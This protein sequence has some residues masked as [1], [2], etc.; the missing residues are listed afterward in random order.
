MFNL[1]QSI[2]EWRRRMITGGIKS[3]VPLEEL[4]NH[5]REHIQNQLCSGATTEQAF[6]TAAK[7][8]GDAHGLKREFEKVQEESPKRKRLRAASIVAG[9]AFAYGAVFT[10]WIL[11]RRS[12][13]I[14]ITATEFL[15]LLGSMAATIIF[16]FIGRR[17]AKLLPVVSNERLQAAAIVAVFFLGAGLLRFVWSCLML[18]SL[19][20]AQL[21]LLWTMSPILGF[22]HCL[23]AW[24]NQCSAARKQRNTVNV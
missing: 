5:L 14:E 1:E 24:C 18:D 9:A 12:G 10:T 20:H 23:S 15:L 7:Q 2:A 17:V 11:A 13:R 3:P 4:E 8:M 21:I 19:V 22:G 6:A 16:G